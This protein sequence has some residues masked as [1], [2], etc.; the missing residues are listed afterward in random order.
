MTPDRTII[1]FLNSFRDEDRKEGELVFKDHAVTQIFGSERFVQARV[2]I[3]RA[4]RVT[5]TKLE[6]GKWEGECVPWD[7]HSKSA[8]VA[9]MLARIERGDKLPAS[10]NEMGQKSFGEILEEKLERPLKRFEEAYIEKLEKRYQRYETKQEILDTDLIRLN[11]KWEVT[12]YDPLELW[13]TPPSNINEFW[14]YIAY[15]FE[16][17]GVGYPPFM[18]VVTNTDQT[19]DDMEQFETAKEREVWQNRLSNALQGTG[20]RRREPST[21]N[22]RLV[23]SFSDARLFA[24]VTEAGGEAGEYS[25]WPTVTEFR[26]ALEKL[27]KNEW[28][29]PAD[30]ALLL[31]YLYDFMNAEDTDLIDLDSVAACRLLNRLFS[32]ESMRQHLYT[33]DDHLFRLSDVRFGWEAR[34]RDEDPDHYAIRLVTDEGKDVPHTVRVLPGIED[35]YLSDETLFRGPNWWLE[36]TSI[37]PEY[38]IEKSFIENP[39][40]V[41]FL[42]RIGAKLPQSL[43]DRVVEQDLFVSLNLR[44]VSALTTADSEHLV[45][46]ITA[47]SDDQSRLERLIRDGWVIERPKDGESGASGKSSIIRYRRDDLMWME[48]SL[49]EV[50]LSYDAALGAHRARVTKVFPERFAEWAESLPESIRLTG[51][52]VVN[53]LLSDP[54]SATVQFEVNQTSIDW[55][56]LKIVVNVDGVDLSQEQ[57]RQLVAAR[58]GFVRMRNGHW[59]RIEIEMD[60]EQ[61]AAVSRLGLDPFDLSGEE[62]RM[63]V[64][65]LADPGVAEVFD[66]KVWQKIENRAQELNTEVKPD[67]PESLQA[68]LRPYQLEGFQFLSYL[69]SNRFGGV[70]A[71]DMGLG[72]TIQ[73]LTW[74]LW[75]YENTPEKDRVPALVVCPKSVLDVWSS[76]IE[77]F[78]PKL[79]VKVIR[80]GDDL[81]MPWIHE[82][83]DVLVLNYAQ[84]R[85]SEKLLD[86]EWQ[87]VVLDE[88]QQIKNPDS[89]AAKAARKLN[90]RNRLVLTGTPIEN[91]LLD[92][93]SLMAF[94]MPGVLGNRAYFRSRFDRRKDTKAQER[95]SAR[96]RPFLLRRTKSQVAIDLPPR[97][98]EDY[99]CEME[100]VQKKLYQDELK[101][102]QRLLLGM[103]TD[104]DLKKNSFAVLQGLTRLRQICCHPGLIDE[105]Y[106]DEESAK[107]NSLFYLLDQLREE[108]HK[109]LVFSQFV[110]MLD[111]IKARL[112]NEKR[113]YSYLTGQTKNRREV[114]D[115]F[116]KTDDPNV[117]LLSLKAGGSGLNLTSASYVILYDPWWNPAVEA[118]AIDRTHRIGQTQKVIAYRLL[119]RDS[120]EQKIRVLQQQKAQLFTDVLGTESFTKTLDVADLHY[121]FSSVAADDRE[122]EEKERKKEEKRKRRSSRSDD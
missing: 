26:S 95:L 122:E 51:D 4:Y 45:A 119:M 120:V 113:P 35:L 29:A 118:Q 80:V 116:Q 105:E 108:G 76:E 27:D 15:A 82:N 17:K 77:K 54:V 11:P 104:D 1:N 47:S 91:R 48:E 109:V 28:A 44:M 40:G 22:V 23:V 19:A 90:A 58:G 83:V 52:D 34:D 3:D 55:F 14:N 57:I 30:V 67:V 78:A 20:R 100:G 32:D 106:L 21:L 79:R 112:E 2:E 53:S 50:G 89:K 46:E 60:E 71:D 74:L 86:I 114:I 101:R 38:V 70:L 99:F 72:K 9:A 92:L 96:L 81:D 121:I 33:L 97:T 63:H 65:Q 66:K 111:I 93:W 25:E 10:P 103:E 84:L 68:T 64:L 7:H 49:E 13:S 12:S 85:L 36:S 6:D 41:E 102:I 24:S 16:K 98:E 56:D 43:Q 8:M 107:M 117:F 110:S 37:E 18:K 73:S 59:M 75:V 69:S 94:A 87:A 61:K 88:G 5:L 62:H 42:A 31:R 115:H 39:E